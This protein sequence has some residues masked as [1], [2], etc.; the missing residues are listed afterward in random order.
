MLQSLRLE[1]RSFTI[2]GRVFSLREGEPGS[3]TVKRGDV[4]YKASIEPVSA[5]LKA[6]LDKKDRYRQDKQN[7]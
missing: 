5:A 1:K 6:P 7:R 4:T 3:L 2:G